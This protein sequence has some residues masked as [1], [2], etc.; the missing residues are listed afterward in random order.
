MVLLVLLGLGTGACGADQ[1]ERRDRPASAPDA[2]SA[3]TPVP[4]SQA[5][6]VAWTHGMVLRQLAGHRLRV[7]GRTLRIDPQ[8]LTCGG[9]GRPTSRVGGEPSWTRFRC[10]Q[11]TFPP[12]SVAG[13]DAILVVEPT[14][15]R[16]FAVTS[17][18]LTRY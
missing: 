1:R 13:P 8:T 10:V 9:V 6:Q 3:S 15:R 14:G 12:G 4:E 5:P 7:G 16:S 2:R 18:R 11:P 17:R